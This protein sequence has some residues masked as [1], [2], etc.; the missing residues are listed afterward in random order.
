MPACHWKLGFENP[1]NKPELSSLTTTLLRNHF[2]AKDAALSPAALQMLVE[3]SACCLIGH[4]PRD[5]SDKNRGP[6]SILLARLFLVDSDS[7]STRLLRR[8][9][10]VSLAAAAFADHHYPRTD[11]DGNPD[12]EDSRE[13]RAVKVLRYYVKKEPDESETLKLFAFGFV[14]VL[15]WL[16]PHPLEVIEADTVSK[17]F[18]HVNRLTTR[19][20]R[21]HTLGAAY[22]FKQERAQAT[23][24]YL[25]S[26]PTTLLSASSEKNIVSSCSQY[27]L[28]EFIAK[29][30]IDLR[31]Y[32][33]SLR[34][35]CS[36][37]S[38]ELQGLCLSAL[39]SRQALTCSAEFLQSVG[40]EKLLG[41]L[42][43]ASTSNT[44][45][46][47][48]AML[49][50]W[51]IADTIITSTDF[52]L[53]SR[54]SALESLIDCQEFSELKPSKVP[55]SPLPSMEELGLVEKWYLQLEE[56]ISPETASRRMPEVVEVMVDFY[57]KKAAEEMFSTE[58]PVSGN[59]IHTWLKKLEAL[60]HNAGLRQ[61]DE[62]RI[63][64]HPDS[65]NTPGDSGPLGETSG[66]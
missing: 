60:T 38:G 33:S 31:L 42:F 24:Q 39:A 44:P 62:T 4:F 22:N 19:F 59:E 40:H 6:L 66:G 34:A 17:S 56:M 26:V 10:A 12:D 61:V 46:A 1:V 52:P 36:A 32:I 54:R 45:V 25:L 57:S 9:I 11:R 29:Q 20:L 50:L 43:G 63:S 58:A 27:L 51:K 2:G 53:E 15:P 5:S 23:F 8:T 65:G 48:T 49:H 47:S 37:H 3:S 13:Q 55:D 30:K 41:T 7:S 16:T 28:P 64:Y 35:L 21:I 18:I 14:G